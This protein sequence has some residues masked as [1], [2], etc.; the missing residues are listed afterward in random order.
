MFSARIPRVLEDA[1][2]VAH[3][4]YDTVALLPREPLTYIARPLNNVPPVTLVIR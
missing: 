2:S 4:A 3:E 1:A